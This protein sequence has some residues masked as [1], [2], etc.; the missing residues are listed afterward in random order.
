MNTYN[1]FQ[2]ASDRNFTILQDIFGNSEKFKLIKPT[3]IDSVYDGILTTKKNDKDV[4]ILIEVKLRQFSL[5]TLIREYDSALFLEKDKY[6]Y[7]HQAAEKLKNPLRE[8][9]IWYLCKTSDGFIFIFDI[10]NKDYSWITSTM[11]SV[12]YTEVQKKRQKKIALLNI[13]D[14]IFTVESKITK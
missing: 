7:L 11:N 13:H 1:S 4:V 5:D 12:T 10:T 9:K 3:R 2:E 14:A 6:T 8:I